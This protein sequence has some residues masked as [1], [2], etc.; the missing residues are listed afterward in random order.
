M[1]QPRPGAS[2]SAFRQQVEARLRNDGVF[3]TPQVDSGTHGRQLTD[4]A[5]SGQLVRLWQG[6]YT[7][8]DEAHSIEM[9][10]RAA[11]LT[12]G[13]PAAACLETAAALWGFDISGDQRLHVL[14][15]GQA[16]TRRAG[17][18]LHRDRFLAPLQ[19]LHG[20]LLTH[21]AET[22]VGLAARL[23]GGP[24]SLAVL[25]RALRSGATARDDLVDIA[26]T[27]GLNH[28][29][30]IRALISVADPAAESPG[31]SW[32]RWAVLHA[33]LA[34]PVLQYWVTIGSRRYRLD[35]A[36]PAQKVACEYDGV[37]FHTGARLAADRERLNDLKSAG[38]IIIHV[39]A[40]LIFDPVRRDTFL[41]H[42]Q[43]LLHTS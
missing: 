42:L 36:W 10:L 12:L 30:K 15:P 38:W 33:E 32:T 40:P 22:A 27:L 13:F 5:G 20:R 19:T 2:S 16:P 11:D 29:R 14:A 21:P 37:E 18:V 31:E 41:R 8:P 24:K 23:R 1:I 43:A 26:D 25:D 35:L 39:T 28:I 9:R 7:T 3:I 17:L 6:A 34:A 4:L